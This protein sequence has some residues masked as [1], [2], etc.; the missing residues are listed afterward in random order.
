MSIFPKLPEI[1]AVVLLMDE[2][3]AYEG[4]TSRLP[5]TN[6]QQIAARFNMRRNV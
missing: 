4:W 2:V 3:R 1:F 5:E 6:L